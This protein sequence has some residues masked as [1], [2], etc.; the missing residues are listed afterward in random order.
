VHR[1]M[2]QHQDQQG[3]G[4][5]LLELLQKRP[6][7]R[8]RAPCRALPLEVLRA[9]RQRAKQGGTVA[10][11]WGRHLALWALAQPAA[12][13]VRRM[14]KMRRS[15]TKACYRPWRLAQAEG[16]A[17]VCHPGFVFSAVGA[18]RGTVVAKRL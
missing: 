3:L 13:D 6:Q 12:R 7:A 5:A 1:G 18:W 8:G 9:Q 14:G 10:L 17:N 15:D 4:K 11:P 16:G 2:I